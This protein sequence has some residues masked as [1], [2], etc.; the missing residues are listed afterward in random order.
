MSRSDD[1]ESPPVQVTKLRESL[2]EIGNVAVFRE[3]LTVFLTDT[4][5]R[6]ERLRQALGTADGKTVRH[7][8]HTL[9]G[10]CGYL[11]AERLARICRELSAAWQ[12]GGGAAAL[13]CMDQL[14]AEFRRV[15]VALERELEG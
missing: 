11:G 3:L 2:A 14:E 4:P 7:V 13:P 1:D 9:R 10:T 12:A 8:V 6:L 15:K 5:G